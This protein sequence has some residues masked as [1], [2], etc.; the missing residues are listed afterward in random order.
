M[1]EIVLQIREFVFQ[2]DVSVYKIVWA[3]ETARILLS[4][5]V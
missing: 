1:L 2:I 4:A 5:S 3:A